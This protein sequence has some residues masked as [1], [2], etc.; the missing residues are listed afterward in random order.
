MGFGDLRQRR[1]IDDLVISFGC[2]P[3]DNGFDW[4]VITRQG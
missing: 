3:L 2:L 1:E 4:D